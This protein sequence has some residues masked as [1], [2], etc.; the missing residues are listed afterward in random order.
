MYSSSCLILFQTQKSFHIFDSFT[1]ESPQKSQQQ[2]PESRKAK[3]YEFETDSEEELNLYMSVPSRSST[4]LPETSKQQALTS[5]ASI[6]ED[7]TIVPP[8]SGEDEDD[9]MTI[10]QLR[11]LGTIKPV[12]EAKDKGDAK[13]E[14]EEVDS[15]TT[16]ILTEKDD[17]N[18]ARSK[19]TLIK[20]QHATSE[21]EFVYDC[22]HPEIFVRKAL[23]TN[24]SK[25]DYQLTKRNT[26]YSNTLF[27][28]PFGCPGFKSSFGN[29]VRSQM[30]KHEPAMKEVDAANEAESKRLLTLLR[31]K[32]RHEHN[33]QVL[34]EGKGEILLSRKQ[35]CLSVLDVRDYGPCPYCFQWL[36][37]KFLRRHLPDC[38][39]LAK[40]DKPVRYGEVR[41][42]S[43]LLSGNLNSNASTLLKNEVFSIMKC[44]K[45][46]VTAQSDPLIIALGNDWITRNIGNKINRSHYTSQLMRLVA[47]LKLELNMD[48]EEGHELSYYIKPD[49]FLTV[50]KAVLRI[51]MQDD[52]NEEEFKAPS[53]A[54]K[55]KYDLKRLACIKLSEAI[56]EKNALRQKDA[57]DF[58]KLM[59]MRYTD[60]LAKVALFNQHLNTRKPL[61]DPHDIKAL[62]EY[63][64]RQLAI[65]DVMEV[66]FE[67][68][69]R[70]I[71]LA[72][73][74]LISFNR[75]RCGE[76]Q[77]VL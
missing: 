52:D 15:D 58:I 9:T 56:I 29:H 65:F 39:A 38:P 21:N 51:S 12:Q 68:Y 61:P 19:S 59:D 63:L 57:E 36:S 24:L 22:N 28:C 67:R 7:I 30:H 46:G 66:S 37:I 41:V 54:I 47:R 62:S 32:G 6:R 42:Q 43:R 64:N 10:A 40:E 35:G 74:K 27:V 1:E 76:V 23:H 72:Q 53:N 50:C 5:H 13:E 4:P 11:C 71:I 31:A 69:K 17:P 77:Q 48:K 25:R 73:A 26:R 45:V 34:K 60:N 33:R 55:M 75:R 20:G 8:T 18:Y 70:A 16:I 49:Q 14:E 3:V 2:M 44:D